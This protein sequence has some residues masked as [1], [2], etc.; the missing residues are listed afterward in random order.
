VVLNG[1]IIVI[2]QLCCGYIHHPEMKVINNQH[3]SITYLNSGD[4][5]ENLS[6]LKYNNGAWSTYRFNMSTI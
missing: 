6:L 1:D 3:G 2:W 4:G 5:V